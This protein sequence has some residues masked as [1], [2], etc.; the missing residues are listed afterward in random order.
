MKPKNL[1]T[2]EGLIAYTNE[3]PYCKSKSSMYDDLVEHV[4]FSNQTL[5]MAMFVPCKDGKPLEKPNMDNESQ[6]LI[7]YNREVDQYIEAEKAVIFDGFKI[8]GGTTVQSQHWRIFFENDR[9]FIGAAI[10]LY[11]DQG[12]FSCKRIVDPTI[13]KLAEHTV[14]NPIK[15]KVSKDE[16]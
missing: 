15:L 10:P 4:S 16:D 2:V 1:L 11:E 6:G 13:K 8:I 9:I 3:Y 12:L 7:E 14:D 5:T